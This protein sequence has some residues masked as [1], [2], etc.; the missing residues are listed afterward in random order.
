[1]KINF[2]AIIFDLG[3]VILNINYQKTIEAFKNLGIQNFDAL[4]TQAQ[5]NHL[6]DKLETGKINEVEF[7]NGI[8]DLVSIELTSQEILT[9]WNAMLLD[10]PE[11]RVS[12]LPHIAKSTPIYLLS[13]TNSIH[14]TALQNTIGTAYGQKSL[15]EDLFVETF[16]SHQIGTRKPHAEA[17]EIII[18]KC[19]LNPEKTLFIDDSEQ[20]IVGAKKVGLQTHHLIN[21]DITTLFNER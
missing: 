18:N 7:Y 11:H 4:Y 19:G 9:A 8:N 17:F 10:L 5:Q 13:N 2:D 12:F 6:F 20:H 16:Y 15:L 21:Q 3:G 1:M 14:L